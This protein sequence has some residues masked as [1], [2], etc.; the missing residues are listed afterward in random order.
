MP[1]NILKWADISGDF[2]NSIILG[3]GASISIDESFKYSS[4]KEHA[5][6]NGLLTESVQA[7]FTFFETDDFE[8]ILRLVWHANKVNSALEIKDESTKVAYEHVRDCLI[9]AVQSIHPLYNEVEEQ[10]PHIEN[11]LSSFKTI[12]SLNYDLTLYW[13]VMYANR[14]KNG[15]SFKDCI[16]HG[17]FDEDWPRFRQ[18]ISGWDRRIS[19]VFY[20]HGSL[21]LARNVVE[22]EIKL[23]SCRHGDLLSSILSSW[24]SGNCVPLFVSEGTSAQK[25]SAIQN[26]HYLNTVYRE[27]IPSLNESL[28]IY[29]WGLGEHDL[30]ILKRLK[31]SE[32]TTVAISVFGNDQA[33]CNRAQQMIKDHVSHAIDVVFFDAQSPGCWNQPLNDSA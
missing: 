1:H 18:S 17:D 11:F 5:V 32:V 24:E 21:V 4:L 12:L 19:L 31:S 9:Q 33:Y 13:V 25:I 28:V 27:V 26:S 14:S 30:H 20:P 15:H 23:D 29:G 6:A 16:I 10:F 22:R 2:S 3:N 7:L 8:L